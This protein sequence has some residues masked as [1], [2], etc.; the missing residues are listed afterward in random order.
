MTLPLIYFK[1][2]VLKLLGFCDVLGNYAISIF[3]EIA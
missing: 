2:I 1:N 3:E